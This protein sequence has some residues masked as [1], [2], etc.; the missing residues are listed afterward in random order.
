MDSAVA[1]C[2]SLY[3]MQ[4]VQV[5]KGL[6]RAPGD[7]SAYTATGLTILILS[8]R[9]LANPELFVGGRKIWS[10]LKRGIDGW[11]EHLEVIAPHVAC[12]PQKIA[13]LWLFP[14]ALAPDV[15]PLR[16]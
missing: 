3:T 7:G 12:D 16:V 8:L 10:E 5:R 13:E 4:L 15:E 14:N 6:Q 11:V 1:G 9:A 2:I